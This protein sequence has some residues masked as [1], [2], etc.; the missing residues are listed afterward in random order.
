MTIRKGDVDEDGVSD[1]Y[2]QTKGT[3]MTWSTT[4]N[5]EG[6]DLTNNQGY[7]EGKDRS[8]MV[9]TA[10]NRPS[11]SRIYIY[12][13][14]PKTEP[15]QEDET[16]SIAP[17]PGRKGILA[18][19]GSEFTLMIFLYSRDLTFYHFFSTAFVA[20]ETISGIS[21]SIGMILAIP[22]TALISSKL[23]SAR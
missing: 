22:L 4:A 11:A 10:T 5:G 3:N 1:T 23:I 9:F 17:D 21:S 15:P 19:L 12:E 16:D 20:L 8:V 2:I 7:L 13:K 6:F 18:F 14:L